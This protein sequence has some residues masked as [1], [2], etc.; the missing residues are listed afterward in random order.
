MCRVNGPVF[1][2]LVSWYLPWLL[3]RA[4]QPPML[5]FRAGS[6]RTCRCHEFLFWTAS[7]RIR[8]S[9][10]LN[11]FDYM[12]GW[13]RFHACSSIIHRLR[14][15][16][17]VPVSDF[18]GDR[19]PLITL[20]VLS[21]VLAWDDSGFVPRRARRDCRYASPTGGLIVISTVILVGQQR[22]EWT[23]RIVFLRPELT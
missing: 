5:S 12:E 21:R 19:P 20:P 15:L 17:T 6:T 9:P 3:M 1:T 7:C 13:L 11:R 22:R 2:I 16:P 8:P 10:C 4:R 18:D 23:V 14:Q